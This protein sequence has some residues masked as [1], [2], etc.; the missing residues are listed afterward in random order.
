MHN[1]SEILIAIGG[2]MLLGLMTDYLGRRTSLPRV[3]LLLLFGMII[4]PN[5]FDLLPNVV[6][7]NFELITNI[8]LVMVGFLVGGKLTKDLLRNI[9]KEVMWLSLGAVL[10]TVFIVLSILVVIG[11]PIEIAILLSCIATATDPAA[12]V[13]VVDESESRGSFAN[14]L[15]SIVAV[16]DAWGLIMFSVGVAMVGLI[17]GTNGMLEPVLSALKEIFGAVLLGFSIGFIASYLTGRVQPGKPILFEALAIVFLCGGLAIWLEVSYLIAAIVVGMTIANFAKHHDCAFHEIENIEPPFLILFFILAGALLEFSYINE[18]GMIALVYVIARIIGK[19]LGTKFGGVI[20]RSNSTVQ[21]W[22]GIALLP[23]AGVAMG[24]A[25]V[26]SNYLPE[27]RQI[28]LSV[29]ISTT[30]F[31]ELCGPVLTNLALKRTASN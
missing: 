8:A 7:N 11:I 1:T 27:H 6:I 31:F 17:T 19:I 23:Q 20:A 28:F 3:T 15:L 12:T 24:M 14:L 18:I 29:A 22:M 4:G 25:L 26:A 2:M 9:G 21:N 16:D 30:V 10:G 13:D 5:G